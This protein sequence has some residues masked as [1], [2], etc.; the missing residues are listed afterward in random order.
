MV[1][2]VKKGINE[3]SVSRKLWLLFWAMAVLLLLFGNGSLFITDSV[4]GNYAL[5]A[6][7][8]VESG[9]WLSPQIY[10]RYWFDKPIFF[11]WLTALAFKVFGFT[12]FAARFFPALFGLAALGLIIFGGKRLFGERAAFYS[13]LLLLSSVEFFLISKSVITDAVLFFFFSG[14]LLFFYLGYR[15]DKKSYWYLM[16]ASSALA[17]LTKGPIGFLLPGLVMVLFLLWQKDFGA[18]R[19]MKLFSGSLLFFAVALPWYAAMYQLHGT[20]FIDG[21]FG[22]H[23]F[24]RAIDSEHPRD[25][26][27]YYYFLVN[28]LALFPWSGLLPALLLDLKRR[29]KLAWSTLK[30]SKSSTVF[31]LLWALTVFFFFQTI[32]TKYLTYTY[33]LL[34]PTFLLLGKT[35]DEKR[36]LLYGKIFLFTVAFGWLLLLAAAYYIDERHLVAIRDLPLLPSVSIVCLL[37]YVE[38]H[39]RLRLS[40]LYGLA[41]S[42]I[43]FYLALIHSIAIPLSEVRSGKELAFKLQ[44]AE[45]EKTVG[46]FGGYSA[47]AVFYSGKQMVK[48]LSEKDAS[49]F[50]PKDTK[51]YSWSSKNVMPFAA[52]TQKNYSSVAVKKEKLRPF[53]E[54]SPDL[55]QKAAVGREWV[56]LKKFSG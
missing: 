53:L 39:L 44:E 29:G 22:V 33:P 30:N 36:E 16:Y 25:D 42:S 19:R 50:L 8:M 9:D 52:L 56:L 46:V 20:A 47:S 45:T 13:G 55:W 40:P 54:E 10:G 37:L 5:T 15:D 48:L 51:K 3:R 17:T 7:E 4:E 2:E 24:L 32:A 35:M 1:G 38:E 21:F 43:V 26:V 14:T 18:L 31:L 49:D 6:K 41:V 11:Y 12:E 28:L 23:N 27:P 34:F